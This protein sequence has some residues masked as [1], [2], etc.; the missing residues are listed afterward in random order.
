MFRSKFLA[1]LLATT[2]TFGVSALPAF[3]AS[4]KPPVKGA[5][6]KK[7]DAN[8]TAKDAKGKTLTCKKDAKG[9]YRWS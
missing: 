2:A 1:A 7:A 9:K 5:F 4:S 3:A 6:C 8:K